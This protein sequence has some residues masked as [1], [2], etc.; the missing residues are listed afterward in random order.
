MANPEFEW[1]RRREGGERV[2]E[3]KGLP[4][5]SRKYYLAL[6]IVLAYQCSTF[7]RLPVK[8]LSATVT[9][10]THNTYYISS[11]MIIT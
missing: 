9:Y 1:E 4:R 5:I 2:R 7:F 11:H 8:K 6:G 3:R 10:I